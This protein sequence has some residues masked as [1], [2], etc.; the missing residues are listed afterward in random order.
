MS[1]QKVPLL[2][3]VFLHEGHSHASAAIMTVNEPVALMWMNE[4]IQVGVYHGAPCLQPDP[5]LLFA[6]LNL[7]VLLLDG[8]I[9]RD[10]QPDLS[11]ILPRLLP[12][13]A[14]EA[15]RRAGAAHAREHS[16]GGLK[17]PGY[18]GSRPHREH[19]EQTCSTVAWSAALQMNSP[20]HSGHSS[21]AL[22]LSL[23]GDS[24]FQALQ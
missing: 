8:S 3:H 12:L 6:E 20:G 18:H 21:R 14:H 7:Y 13:I 1:C 24:P 19:G 16:F 4:V 22:V 15:P 17:L 11:A 23:K 2:P 10:V 5:Q 9:H